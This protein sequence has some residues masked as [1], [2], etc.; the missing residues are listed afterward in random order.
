[1]NG[2]DFQQLAGMAWVAGQM[3]VSWTFLLIVLFV[4][5]VVH[6]HDEWEDD[7]AGYLCDR[8]GIRQCLVWLTPVLALLAV[9]NLA[10]PLILYAL[11]PHSAWGQVGLAY[12]AG[13]FLGDAVCTHF[14]PTFL[15]MYPAP[16]LRTALLYLVGGMG[17]VQ[18]GVLPLPFC[19][20]ILSFVSLWPALLVLRWFLN[21][22]NRKVG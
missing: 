8:V 22:T 11:A 20:G 2:S 16:A 12:A 21:R 15:T 13:G 19:V 14:L 4:L 5:I 7:L 3:S 17:L 18:Q 6:A 1:M 10:F 9:G